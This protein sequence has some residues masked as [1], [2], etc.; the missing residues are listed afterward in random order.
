MPA[1]MDA[2]GED[3]GGEAGCG[4]DMEVR[5]E[6]MR[7]RGRQGPVPF[8]VDVSEE[9]DSD[10]EGM[11]GP[12]AGG[13]K[14][15]GK[16]L[17][18]SPTAA[19]RGEPHSPSLSDRP[20]RPLLVALHSY[21]KFGISPSDGVL[22]L[23]HAGFSRVPFA[24]YLRFQSL[25]ANLD[26]WF[27]PGG[28]GQG[29]ESSTSSC[30]QSPRGRPR[31]TLSQARLIIPRTKSEYM[32]CCR[33]A[34]SHTEGLLFATTPQC[35]VTG[36]L[37]GCRDIAPRALS[38]GLLGGRLCA[39]Q[40]RDQRQRESE[41]KE[42]PPTPVEELEVGTLLEGRIVRIA[43]IGFFIDV[44]ATR[45]GLLT[46]RQCRLAPKQML[47]KGE[48]FSNLVVLNVNRK[49]RQFT[50]GLRGIGQGGDEIEEEAYDAILRRIAAWAG[51]E[52]PPAEGEVSELAKAVPK[53]ERDLGRPGR[54][55]AGARQQQGRRRRG[56]PQRRQQLRWREVRRGSDVAEDVATN[57]AA[58]TELV[59]TATHPEASPGGV[60]RE[61]QRSGGGTAAVAPSTQDKAGGRSAAEGHRT[62]RGYPV[63]SA[64]KGRGRG[65]GNQVVRWVPRQTPSAAAA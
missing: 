9:E 13:G 7:S 10:F 45:L 33:F 32:D 54:S 37:A 25:P 14:G 1:A 63:T 29:Y 27:G 47:K 46:R 20:P 34:R 60:G 38:E 49:K 2:D 31:L 22:D 53:G 8:E 55:N 17:G 28:R 16:G 39:A 15:A 23:A 36:E 43:R 40:P 61:D 26:N 5:S 56:Q 50:L 64:A 48:V 52:L 65:R 42:V 24:A 41:P 11:R 62:A 21:M 59:K 4:K 6:R 58:T 44:H 30:R 18:R 3:A 12:R 35:E 57:G 51:V 19:R